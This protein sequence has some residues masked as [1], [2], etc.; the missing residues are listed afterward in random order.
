MLQ[1]GWPLETVL[2]EMSQSQRPLTAFF[3]LY[4]VFVVAVLVAVQS[5]RW[6]RFFVTPW[7]TACQAPLPLSPR[8]CSNSFPLSHWC[9]LTI[10]SSAVP[11][12]FCPQSFPAL[13]SFPMSRLFE[14]GGQRIRSS[15]LAPSYHR[16]NPTQLQCYLF[17]TGDWIS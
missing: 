14:W 6:V 17:L 1:Y 2:N 3:Y 5:L 4:E 11:F 15:A 16:I 8:V 13:G 9:N 10:S 12:S 7:A